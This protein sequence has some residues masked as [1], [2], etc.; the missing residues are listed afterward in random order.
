ARR[1]LDALGPP[2]RLGSVDIDFVTLSIGI[3]LF[4]LH[5]ADAGSLIKAADHAMYQAKLERNKACLFS[6]ATLP[7][8]EQ[9]Q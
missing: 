8:A 9:N 5:A 6:R 1:M 4:P 2:L 7:S 3:A